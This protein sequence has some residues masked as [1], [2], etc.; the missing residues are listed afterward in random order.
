[1]QVKFDLE[2]MCIWG[3]GLTDGNGKDVPL[4]SL[5]ECLH[6]NTEEN[7]V[8]R[9]ITISKLL[10]VLTFQMNELITKAAQR[11][12]MPNLDAAELGRIA[13]DVIQKARRN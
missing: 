12:N 5:A 7:Q 9:T 2:N 3:E 6:Q 13:T 1:M 11:P 10:L 8:D 4:V